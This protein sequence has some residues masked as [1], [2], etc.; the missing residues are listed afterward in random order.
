M[1]YRTR[2]KKRHR[3][4]ATASARAQQR[5][6][7]ADRYYLTIVSRKASCNDCGGSLR[8]GREC[9]YRYRPKE[10]LC[11][12][13]ADMRRLYYRPSMRWES[14]ERKGPRARKSDGGAAS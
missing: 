6:K 12:V 2:E 1:S 13:C 14:A 7:H 9:V 10:I 3:K 5:E 4:I 8:E 11:K